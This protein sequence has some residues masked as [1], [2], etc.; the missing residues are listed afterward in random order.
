M[1]QRHAVTSVAWADSYTLSVGVNNG[2]ICIIDCYTNTLHRS[3]AIHSERVSVLDWKSDGKVLASSGADKFIAIYDIRSQYS[4][5]STHLGHSAEVCGLKWSPSDKKLASGGED[6]LVNIWDLVFVPVVTSFKQARCY[7]R[8]NQPLY[9]FDKH[10]AATKALAWCPWMGDE[11]LVSGGSIG[12]HSLNFWKARTG[13]CLKTIDTGSQITSIL[14]SRNTRELVTSHGFAQHNLALWSF[15]DLSRL[16]SMFEHKEKILQTALSPDGTTVASLGGDEMV[17]FWKVF[18]AKKGSPV[19][20]PAKQSKVN[21][22]SPL[23][24]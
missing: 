4:L 12:D 24:R 15:P 20:V 18:E 6:G 14:W 21:L 17:R 16:A 2:H 13:E 10:T 19:L 22:N 11:L 7:A 9:C 3:F 8:R 23:I 1:S 5:L